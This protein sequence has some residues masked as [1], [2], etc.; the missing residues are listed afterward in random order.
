MVATTTTTSYFTKKPTTS[1][2]TISADGVIQPIQNTT[3]NLVGSGSK[4][5]QVP[6]QGRPQVTSTP[7]VATPTAATPPVATPVATPPVAK[8]STG[9]LSVYSRYNIIDGFGQII[10]ALAQ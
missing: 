1:Q 8:S 3:P 7:P 6:I 5:T 9:G 10:S 2:V 4:T